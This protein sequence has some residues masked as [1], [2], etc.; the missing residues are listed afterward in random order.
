MS[1]T[2]PVPVFRIVPMN[3][4]HAE[5]ICTWRYDAPYDVYNLPPWDTLRENREE[6]GDPH[7]RATQYAAVLDE[8][9]ELCGFAQFF[10]IT[11]V[12]RLG[13]GMRPDLCGQGLGSV[14]VQAIVREALRRTPDHEIDLE[15]LTWNL[16]ARK[17]YESAGFRVTDTYERNTPSGT[18]EFHCMVYSVPGIGRTGC[19]VPRSEAADGVSIDP[20][21]G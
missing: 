9:G 7:I 5:Q 17:A 18:A 2:K 10:P 12:T 1:V 15:V 11:G 8:H 4:S 21:N 3:E 13:L 20:M 14:F 19:N 16:R 6:F